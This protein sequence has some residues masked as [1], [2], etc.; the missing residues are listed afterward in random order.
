[1]TRYRQIVRDFL[2]YIGPVANRRLENI[3][4]D[5]VLKFRE[6][7]ESRGL[8]VTTINF[9]NVVPMSALDAKA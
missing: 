3:T 9:K 1:M 8:A 2:V 7:L 4:T 5:D 6:Q